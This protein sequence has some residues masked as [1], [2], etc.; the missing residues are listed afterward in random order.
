MPRLIAVLVA[1]PLVF[2]GC[3]GGGDDQDRPAELRAVGAAHGCT[4]DQPS[5]PQV[6]LA[7]LE[8]TGPVPIEGV[9]VRTRRGKLVESWVS[10]TV[11]DS[12]PPVYGSTPLEEDVTTEALQD[13]GWVTR[14]EARGAELEAGSYQLFAHVDFAKKG[15]A[16]TSFAIRWKADG[17]VHTLELVHRV[18]PGC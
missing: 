9:A 18:G 3:A 4:P 11:D 15:G 12:V 10:P 1:L 16:V 2:T 14:E 6:V 5:G 8:A 7:P 13:Q 17:A